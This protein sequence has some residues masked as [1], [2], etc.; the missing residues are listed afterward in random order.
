MATDVVVFRRWKH[1]FGVIALLPEIPADRD[2]MFC[3]S[4]E[5]IGQHGGADYFG[6]VQATVKVGRREYAELRMN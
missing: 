5:S 3:E 1:G 4:Y 6:V 2:G